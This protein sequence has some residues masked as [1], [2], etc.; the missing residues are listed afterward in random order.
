MSDVP[1]QAHRRTGMKVFFAGTMTAQACALLRYVVLARILGPDQ[2][3]LAAILILTSQFLDLL[4][5]G[6]ITYYLIQSKDGDELRVQSMIQLVNILRC[7]FMSATLLVIAQPVADFYGRPELVHGVRMLSIAPFLLGF[8]HYDVR[9]LQRYNR[10]APEGW[11]LMFSEALSLA[12]S[13]AAAFILRDSTAVAYGL[14]ARSLVIVIVSHVVAERRYSVSFVRESWQSLSKFSWPLVING[15]LLFVCMQGDRLFIG[16]QLGARELGHYAAILLLIYY[17]TGILTRL[18]NS[19]HMPNIAQAREDTALLNNRVDLLAGHYLLLGIS[20]L[21]GFAAL[22]PFMVPLLYGREFAQSVYIIAMIGFL[23]IARF[24]RGW[25]TAFALATGRSDQVLTNN[26]VRLIAFPLAL[27][28]QIVLTGLDGILIG[29]TVGEILAFAMATF[30]VDRSSHRGARGDLLLILAFIACGVA[31]TA[32]GMAV[33]HGQLLQASALI[34]V[35]LLSAGWIA[36]RQRAAI[37]QALVLAVG[38]LRR[39]SKRSIAG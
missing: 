5:E 3:G 34:V 19:M 2:L 39:F 36:L 27:A 13:A 22:M 10:F 11:M 1:A 28:G 21:I 12:G 8:M 17:P 14:A 25:P 30:M 18:I 32:G 37:E 31:V 29:F 9:R 15:V 6:G 23:Q 33:D 7:S 35:A 38:A 4:T 24:L 20:M 16:K 26:I